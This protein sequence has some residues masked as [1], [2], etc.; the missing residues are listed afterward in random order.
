MVGARHRPARD[1]RRHYSD[2]DLCQRQDECAEQRRLRPFSRALDYNARSQ[3]VSETADTL[4]GSDLLRSI[5]SYDYGVGAGYALG[6][7][8]TVSVQ[9]LKNGIDA[10]TGGAPDTRTTNIYA[11]WDG[12]VLSRTTYDEDTGNASNPLFNSTY[13]YNASGVLTSAQV[14]DGRPHTLAYTNGID[15]QVI[16]RDEGINAPHEVFY[17]FGGKQM[18]VI[19]T[20]GTTNTDYARSIAS[21]Q[22]TPAPSTGSGG[23]YRNGASYGGWHADFGQDYDAVNSYA[24]GGAGGGYT[25]RSGDTLA[26]IAAQL[27]GDSA[28]W[29][30]LAEANGLGAQSGLIAGQTLIIPTGVMRLHHNAATFKPY[31]PAAALGDTNPTT[32]KPQVQSAGTSTAR[33]PKGRRWQLW[34]TLIPRLQISDG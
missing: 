16:R 11:Y 3:V 21:R 31:D 13:K 6:A 2:H 25:V 33:R 24:Q 34:E 23:A 10:G 5:A 9:N 7:A 27:W 29:Y 14:S 12:A 22:A 17:R 26:S 18:G 1:L 19:G 28:L 4:R 15:G 32:P 20:N 30:K 8:L